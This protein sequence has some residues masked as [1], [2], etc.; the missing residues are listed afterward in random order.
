MLSKIEKFF[1]DRVQ[2]EVTHSHEDIERKLR[3]ATTVLFLEVAHAD[4]KILTEE[5]ERITNIMKSIFG[6]SAEEIE[7]LLS[8]ARE[9]RQE[10]NDIWIF[11]NLLKENFDRQKRF[12]ILE[13]LWLIIYAD[14]TVDKYEDR[15]IRK[16]TSLLGLEHG[17]MIQA[18]RSAKQKIN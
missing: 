6:L 16:I 1:K 18:K 3:I 5:E 11:T 8:L 13:K 12:N 7:E 14:G 9:A 2:I 10:R 4:L 15:L 17:D